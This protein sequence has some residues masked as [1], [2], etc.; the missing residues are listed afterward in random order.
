[1]REKEVEDYLLGKSLN[2]ETI[3]GAIEA[4]RNSMD[5]RL[6]GRPTLPYKR[7]AISTIL[8]EILEEALVFEK[9]VKAW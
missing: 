1:M 3:E 4:L 6:K 8:R 9:G 2:E 7:I 5:E